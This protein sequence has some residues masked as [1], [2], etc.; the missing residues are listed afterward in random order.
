MT[1]TII[2]ERELPKGLKTFY[3]RKKEAIKF[4][5]EFKDIVNS[6]SNGAYQ[7]IKIDEVEWSNII[8]YEPDKVSPM[9]ILGYESSDKPKIIIKI[10]DH[11][12]KQYELSEGYNH[13]NIQAVS[14]NNYTR[15]I[16]DGKE[17][18][19]YYQCFCNPISAEYVRT[20]PYEVVRGLLIA[21]L[22]GQNLDDRW[23]T[24]YSVI[25]DGIDQ[26]VQTSYGDLKPS[27]SILEFISG[28]PTNYINGCSEQTQIDIMR[29]FKERVE[30]LEEDEVFAK[31]RKSNNYSIIK[32][33]DINRTL[34]NLVSDIYPIIGHE[35]LEQFNIEI[36]K[37]QCDIGC[38]G[39]GS[40]GTAV[41]DQVARMSYFKNYFLLDFDR[42][43]EKNLNNQ[44]YTRHQIG[45]NKIGGSKDNL[46][47]INRQL[48]VDYESCKF[49]GSKKIEYYKFKYVIS[50]F[51]S[52]CARQDFIKYLEEKKI[53]SDYLI[54]LRYK[55]LECSLYF[56]DL[57]DEAQVT[58]YKNMLNN[59]AQ[60][61]EG[62]ENRILIKNVKQFL[63]FWDDNGFFN[64]GCKEAQR[65]YL[66]SCGT[67]PSDNTRYQHSCS[68][69]R[70][71][72]YLIDRYTEAGSPTIEK[73]ESKEE[74]TCVKLN[75]MDI[76]KFT[77][78]IVFSAIREIEN[79]RPKPFTHID[80]QTE[81]IPSLV[82]MK[83]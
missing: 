34:G 3:E 21:N 30:S 68:S 79:G 42:V 74:N 40:A 24:I 62:I 41:L 82:T 32:K 17:F 19:C 80:A 36:P 14:S 15:I 27:A 72:Q 49:Q 67:C 63:E 43:E 8:T 61:F 25:N 51:D 54:D 56:I 83:E 12:G 1:T 81:G 6:K 70:C 10:V 66:G 47:S 39:L 31:L 55:D 73:I 77:G 57:K 35:E 23:T 37:T 29:K 78:A 11:N 69:S 18:V 65:E 38:F 53:L 9:Y 16:V 33:K 48:Q 75:Y 64:K 76:Y 28:V 46:L 5:D 22:M 44:W 52:I 60:A 45:G 71:Q 20:N 7:V 58:Y 26:V 13:I 59:D 4:F 50:G 2:E